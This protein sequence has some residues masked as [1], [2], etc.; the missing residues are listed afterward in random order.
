MLLFSPQAC[1][2]LTVPF[3]PECEERPVYTG[4]GTYL[5]APGMSAL[6]E[7]LTGVWLKE[8]QS[9]RKRGAEPCNTFSLSSS[10]EFATSGFSFYV[11]GT[12]RGSSASDSA[13]AMPSV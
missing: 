13:H 10:E 7:M 8:Q 3:Q 5:P 11:L 1:A 4:Q 6:P 2:I 12:L 9:V